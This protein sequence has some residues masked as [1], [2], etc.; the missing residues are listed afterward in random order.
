MI[1]QRNENATLL[2]GTMLA[3]C[4]AIYYVWNAE[5]VLGDPDIWW[6]IKTGQ[7]IFSNAALPQTDGYSFTHAGQPWIAKEWLSQVLFASVFS[8]GKWNAVLFSACL[9]V[10]LALFLIYRHMATH[11]RPSFVAFYVF[12]AAIVIAPMILARPHIFTLPLAV[13]LTQQLFEAAHKRV[14]PPFWLLAIIVLWA[15]LHGSFMIAFVI[16]AFAFCDAMEQSRLQDKALI[17]RWLTFL[18]LCPIVSLINPYGMTPFLIGLK[19]L[20]GIDAMSVIVEWQPFNAPIHPIVEA[21]FLA[22]LAC[23]LLA[24]PKLSFSKVAFILFMTHSMFTHIRFIYLFFLLVPIVVARDIGLSTEAVSRSSWQ[25]VK[26]LNRIPSNWGNTTLCAAAVAGFLITSIWKPFSPPEE[27]SNPDAFK[28]ISE[29]RNAGHILNAYNFGGP[30]I[31]NGVKTF[32]DGRADQIFLGQFMKDYN[33][34][35]KAG[36]DKVMAELLRRHDISWTMFPP[37]DLENEYMSQM[38]GWKKAFSDQ[39]AIIYEKQK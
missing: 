4:A 5:T 6:H 30:L 38:P 9:S 3:L 25:D 12:A 14:A 18:L 10:S 32:I 11:I 24:R 34:L 13:I 27:F 31:F 35:G 22:V 33:N 17:M 29:N 16:A 15:N 37:G 21:G 1:G 8:I 20:S 23:L 2:L 7:D 26:L 19:L 39:N 28:Y 36:G